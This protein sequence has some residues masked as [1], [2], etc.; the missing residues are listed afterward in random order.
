M[1]ALASLLAL[2]SVSLSSLSMPWLG[3]WLAGL[4]VISVL[5][6]LSFKSQPNLH[7]QVVRGQCFLLDGQGLEGSGASGV[8]AS[9]HPVILERGWQLSPWL[10]QLRYRRQGQKRWHWQ[11]VWPDS[12]TPETRRLLRSHEAFGRAGTDFHDE[13]S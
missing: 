7:W 11:L 8:G 9:R 1:T 13:S 4:L 12:A 6:Y 10:V 2:V 5:G 3:L